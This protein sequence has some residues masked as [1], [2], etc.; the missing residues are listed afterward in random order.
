MT[1]V[2]AVCRFIALSCHTSPTHGPVPNSGSRPTGELSPTEYAHDRLWA[3]EQRFCHRVFTR[4]PKRAVARIVEA[5]LQTR[6]Q[7]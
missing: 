4:W 3:Q 1:T 5:G 2:K 6:L 7:A